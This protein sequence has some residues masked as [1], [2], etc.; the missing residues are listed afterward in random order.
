MPSSGN[1]IHDCGVTSATFLHRSSRGNRILASKCSNSTIAIIFNRAS[2]SS[3]RRAKSLKKPSQLDPNKTY[4]R[5]DAKT[6]LALSA[7]ATS[8]N[9][10]PPSSS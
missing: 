6:F 1:G 10:S 8:K 7:Y 2:N 9:D 5:I 4:L 3:G